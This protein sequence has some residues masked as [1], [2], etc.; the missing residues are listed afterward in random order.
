MVQFNQHSSLDVVSLHSEPTKTA[1]FAMIKRF[2]TI[3]SSSPIKDQVLIITL[4]GSQ[5]HADAKHSSN[6]YALLFNYVHYAMAP[7]FDMHS[8]TKDEKEQ[9]GMYLLDLSSLIYIG[10]F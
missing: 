5:S 4:P 7:Y 10:D 2:D 8:S 1:L 3:T 6:D 9:S